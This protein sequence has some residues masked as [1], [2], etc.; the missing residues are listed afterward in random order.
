M[1]EKF[2]AM[3]ITSPA[4]AEEVRRLLVQAGYPA[5]EEKSGKYNIVL[6]PMLTEEQSGALQAFLHGL[7]TV[8]LTRKPVKAKPKR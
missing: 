7:A 3:V 5:D 4:K 2:E 1:E 6:K 8:G